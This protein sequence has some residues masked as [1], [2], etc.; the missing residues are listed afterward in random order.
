MDQSV[1]V[2]ELHSPSRDDG[3][4]GKTFSEDREVGTDG[5]DIAA[6]ERVYRCACC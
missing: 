4:K 5:E 3:V 2:Q 1:H 6:I